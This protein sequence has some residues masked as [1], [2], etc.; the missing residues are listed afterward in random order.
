M[1]GTSLLNSTVQ[2]PPTLRLRRLR[3]PFLSRRLSPRSTRPSC[4]EIERSPAR[5]IPLPPGGRFIPH[6]SFP[7]PALSKAEGS[8]EPQQ[9]RIRERRGATSWEIQ[10]RSNT[11]HAPDRRGGCHHPGLRATSNACFTHEPCP[12]YH[13]DLWL[14]RIQDRNDACIEQA[15]RSRMGNYWCR[16][17]RDR[18]LS[19]SAS[20]S[21][22]SRSAVVLVT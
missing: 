5:I 14:G 19:C 21:F 20:R 12:M 15:P 11:A 16:D 18:R 9:S 4:R 22:V 10:R 1:A 8:M 3:R 6:R 2:T 13:S 7:H 17:P